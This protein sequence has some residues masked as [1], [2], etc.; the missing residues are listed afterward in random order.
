MEKFLGTLSKVFPDMI[1]ARSI[2]NMY[3]IIQKEPHLRFFVFRLL[4]KGI[5]YDIEN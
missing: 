2:S 1:R 4:F 5:G 3:E